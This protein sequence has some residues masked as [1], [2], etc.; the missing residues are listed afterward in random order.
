MSNAQPEPSM[1]EILASI[2][3]IISED[4][5]E[6]L[7]VDRSSLDQPDPPVWSAKEDIEDK[8]AD[9]DS[10]AHGGDSSLSEMLD[11]VEAQ[12]AVGQVRNAGVFAGAEVSP[13]DTVE[14]EIVSV[15]DENGDAMACHSEADKAVHGGDENEDSAKNVISTEDVKMVKQQAALRSETDESIIDEDTANSAT[16]AFASLTRS[17][18][19]ADD[20]GQTLEAIVT[21]MLRP[22]IK[23]WLDTNLSRIVEEKVE[24]EVQRL[25]RR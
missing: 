24:H 7:G 5:E 22:M 16:A 9:T 21:E 2:R 4:E 12:H 23:E 18:R 13:S 25:A 15:D 1:E 17:V 20:E 3:R 14:A 19:V 11:R 8:P 10:A 6:N